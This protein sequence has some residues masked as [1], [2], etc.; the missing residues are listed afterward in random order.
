MHEKEKICRQ[1]E[2]LWHGHKPKTVVQIPEIWCETYDGFCFLLYLQVFRTAGFTSLSAFP[3]NIFLN[4]TKPVT[5]K[6]KRS[7]PNATAACV[8]KSDYIWSYQSHFWTGLFSAVLWDKVAFFPSTTVAGQPEVNRNQTDHLVRLLSL[9]GQPATSHLPLHTP[10]W[11][12]QSPAGGWKPACPKHVSAH[13]TPAC[14]QYLY[15]FGFS[16]LHPSA[17]PQTI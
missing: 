13:H 3:I 2:V 6:R 10:D 12:L 5:L 14:H 17:S 7:D 8:T 16:S 9:T 4:K 11:L 1:T 15:Y